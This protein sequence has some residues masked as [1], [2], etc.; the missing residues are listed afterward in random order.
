MIRTPRPRRGNTL[1]LE[2]RT[3]EEVAQAKD[4]D[5]IHMMKESAK[6]NA[7]LAEQRGA[8]RP[9]QAFDEIAV[10]DMASSLT[11]I[12]F[13]QSLPIIKDSDGGL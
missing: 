2:A 1:P 12:E 9:V 6:M 5:M 7:S 8:S 4:E 13:K 3:P 11:G 10:S